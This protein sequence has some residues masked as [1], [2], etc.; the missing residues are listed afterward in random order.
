MENV[1]DL[2][3]QR[4]F[5]SQLTSPDVRTAL[6]NPPATAYVGFDP[7]ADSLHL[8]H[9]VPIMALAHLQR[10]GHRVLVV[11]GGA[12]GM[13]GDPSGRSTERNLLTMEQVAANVLAV[14]GQMERFLT[15][16]GSDGAL[17]LDNHDWIAPMTFIDWLRDVGKHFGI[18]TMLGK[19]SVRSR[20]GSEQ[21]ITFTEFAYMT[22]QAYDFLHLFDHHGCTIQCGGND[23]WGNITAGMDL[24]QKVRGGRA[25]G[26]TFP[27]V[28]TATGAKFGKSA[29]NAVWLDA[30]RT[31]PFRF[32]QYWLNTEDGDVA[33][34]LKLF[35]FLPLEQIRELCKEHEQDP[36]RRGAQRMLASETTRLVH[37]EA[38]LERAVRATDALFGGGLEGLS[39]AELADVFSDV[40]STTMPAGSLDGD[41][42]PV[43]EL[44]TR[45]SVFASK[46]EARRMLDQGGLYLNS[47]RVG[48][49]EERVSLATLEG[50]RVLIVRLGKKRYHM[51]RFEE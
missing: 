23:Q 49:P 13:V 32:Y 20:L 43:L 9:V 36:G 6:G 14:K 51:V 25:Y 5:I 33:R 19:E 18:G 7:T 27:L 22:M 47:R 24:I 45:A 35:T 17:M 2:I 8:G 34:F 30:D 41:G 15:F 12:T 26:I 37:G 48:S 44:L 46:G 3:E 31:S 42:L 50:R 16:G 39:E 10:A 28:T 4:G 11:I 1:F 38:G 29:G 21:G 40:P